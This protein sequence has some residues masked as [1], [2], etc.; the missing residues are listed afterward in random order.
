RRGRPA[1]VQL[2]VAGPPH[3]LRC[4]APLLPRDP[5]R[6]GVHRRLVHVDRPCGGPLVSLLRP[7]GAIPVMVERAEARRA[8][9]L[10]LAPEWFGDRRWLVLLARR[11]VAL[12]GAV[13]LAAMLVLGLVGP[14]VAGNPTHMDVAARLGAPS[15]A[16]WFG[17]DDVG[18]DVFSRVIHGAR[19]SLLVGAAVVAFA[20]AVGVLCGL[21]AGYFKRLDNVVMRVM[22]G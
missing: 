11:K 21:I 16:H 1:R 5:G 13:L 20:F 9:R 6:R 18:R 22:D 2:S 3:H 14:L 19:L 15:R 8:A 4:L 7:P 10:V 17:T 12:V